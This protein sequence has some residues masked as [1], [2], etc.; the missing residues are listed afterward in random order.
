MNDQPLLTPDH[1]LI[2]RLDTKLDALHK[3][4]TDA[5]NDTKE[6]LVTLETKKLDKDSFNEFFSEY[7]L[8]RADKE[9]RLRFLERWAWIL[10]G[11]IILSQFAIIVYV[12]FFRGN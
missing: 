1:D 10:W 2:I 6:R 5:N 4:V 9:R 3:A 11:A 8:E 7:K 12:T